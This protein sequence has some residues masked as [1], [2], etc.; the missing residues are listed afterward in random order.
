MR[1]KTGLVVAASVLLGLAACT[2]SHKKTTT[3]TSS[4]TS[5]TSTSSSS[6]SS[7]AGPSTTAAST[8]TSTMAGGPAACQPSSLTLKTVST[9]GFTGHMVLMMSFT[10]TGHAACTMKGWP[11]VQLVDK[12]G[13]PVATNDQRVN[14]FGT[15]QN[16]P[17]ST[18]S[19]SPGGSAYFGVET[20]DV[21]SDTAP[22]PTSAMLAIPPNQTQ[23]LKASAD[24]SFCPN[25]TVQ[26]T[27]VRSK[28]TDVA[29][30]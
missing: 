11:G 23:Q 30:G 2:S 10:N 25:P 21:C 4:S 15:N 19:V 7:T 17:P 14:G 28:Q 27:P 12:S 16:T 29:P 20:E 13:H 3:T 5:S 24:T 18:V 1:S 9:E 8:S 22:Q 26:V 6:T